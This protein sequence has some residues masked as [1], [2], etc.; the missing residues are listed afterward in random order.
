M[1]KR[2][3]ILTLV[4]AALLLLSSIAVAVEF[5]PDSAKIT[6][7]YLP[8]ELGGW[9]VK[10]GAGFWEGRV[11]YLHAVG[12]ETVSGAKPERKFLTT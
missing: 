5:G 9:Q 10:L 11:M 8:A 1:T 6:N 12:I 2:R 4:F 3:V 7:R